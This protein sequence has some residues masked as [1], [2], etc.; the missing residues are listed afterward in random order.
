M[1]KSAKKKLVT[2]LKK[3]LRKREGKMRRAMAKATPSQ[4]KKLRFAM[5]RL[6]TAARVVSTLYDAKSCLGFD[7]TNCVYSD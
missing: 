1:A 4:K 3:E 2:N 6:D 5:K 7:D